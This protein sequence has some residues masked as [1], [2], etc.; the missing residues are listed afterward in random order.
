MIS[1]GYKKTFII[2]IKFL[3]TSG[4]IFWL[5]RG[6]YENFKSMLLG[7]DSI[8]FIGAVVL[9][10]VTIFSNAWRWHIFI[11]IQ[12]INISFLSVL[13]LSARSLF[14]S[15]VIPLGAI[16]GDVFKI[17]YL[18]NSNKK[19][20]RLTALSTVLID[21]FFGMIGQFVLGVLMA[22][23]LYSEISK[24]N[25]NAMYLMLILFLVSMAGLA[26]GAALL[27]HRKLE[28]FFVFRGLFQF[29]DK[30]T[31]GFVS[32]L[33]DIVDSYVCRKKEMFYAVLI[34]IFPIQVVS[35]VILYF[36][37]C[38]IKADPAYIAPLLLAMSFGST[39]GLLPITPSGFGTRDIVIKTIL[40][41]FGFT[42][43]S[44]IAIPIIFSA[45]MLLVNIFLGIGFLIPLHKGKL[46]KTAVHKCN[47]AC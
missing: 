40:I 24:T 45:I 11:R 26:C 2:L 18:L 9:Y 1:L 5:L 13:I 12:K 15:L 34:S 35:G 44:A 21:R 23:V 46:Q 17:G 10:L 33:S 25:T 36:I 31:K 47:A 16:S 29:G 8:W 28:R 6:N 20:E 42:V 19:G 32:R 22:L 3:I 39:A 7:I 4:L 27:I 30:I 37:A 38:G 14:F 43:S 41:S